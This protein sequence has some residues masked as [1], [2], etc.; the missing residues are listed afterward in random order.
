MNGVYLVPPMEDEPPA[1][2]VTF[3][4]V[5]LSDLQRE[6]ARL[7]GGHADE[8][9][10]DALADIAGHWR[11]LRLRRRLTHRDAAGEF[12]THRLATRAKQW[13]DDQVYEVEVQLLRPPVAAGARAAS[14]ALRKAALLPDTVRIQARPLA[15]ASI[16]WS[17]ACRQARR[18]GLAR[19][20]AAVALLFIFL[21]QAAPYLPD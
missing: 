21:V 3:V 20:A 4:A 8:V 5:C 2:F 13:R 6:A 18:H 1:D 9:Y 7:T 12:L 11:R 17:H 16:A 15:E 10:P 19:T 14:I